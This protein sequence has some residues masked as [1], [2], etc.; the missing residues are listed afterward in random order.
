[1]LRFLRLFEYSGEFEE[2]YSRVREEVENEWLARK[3]HQT[4]RLVPKAPLVRLY[5]EYGK[6]GRIN[7]SIL[8]NVRTILH[9]A[10]IKVII[11]SETHDH[12]RWPYGQEPMLTAAPKSRQMA[13]QSEFDLGDPR[14]EEPR[15]LP[16]KQIEKLRDKEWD[17]WFLFVSDLSNSPYI[18][19]FGEVKG[20][21]RYSDCSRNLYQLLRASYSADTPESQFVAMDRL[22]NF[23]HGLGNMAKWFVE[24]GVSTLDQIANFAPQGVTNVGLR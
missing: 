5:N 15:D 9:D 21:A 17:R 19:N 23:A 4:W 12:E 24:G 18:R 6:Y 7:E 14:D 16:E 2:D 11:N 10:A 8:L 3:R 1:M 13:N 20:N 22:L